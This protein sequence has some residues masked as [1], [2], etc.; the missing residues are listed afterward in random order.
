MAEEK[1]VVNKSTNNTCYA[2]IVKG[3]NKNRKV[4]YSLV[5]SVLVPSV[6]KVIPFKTIYLNEFDS[7]MLQL[8]GVV[9]YDN[10]YNNKN[11]LVRLVRGISQLGN[12]YHLFDISVV[13]DNEITKYKQT[14]VSDWEM[15]SLTK[16][17]GF[18][19]IDIE[20]IKLDE[21]NL[22]GGLNE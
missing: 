11:L 20:T 1:K 3:I 14:L 6:N 22:L 21:N 19:T 2:Q 13:I 17:C 5:I 16:Q 10:N 18:T 7:E 4:S 12:V 9:N 15:K 8:F